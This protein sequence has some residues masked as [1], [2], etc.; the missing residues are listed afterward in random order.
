[1][2]EKIKKALRISHNKLDDDIQANIDACLLDLTIAGV[3]AKVE[4]ELM[5]Q[6]V[7]LYCKWQYD[8]CGNSDRFEK[9]YCNLKMALALCGDY[10]ER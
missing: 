1:M 6:A 2:L 10:N 7:K 9:A 3:N 8:F 4:D 5:T